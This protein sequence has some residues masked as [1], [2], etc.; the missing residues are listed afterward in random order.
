MNPN[1]LKINPPEI[2]S[3]YYRLCLFT[4]IRNLSMEYN[5]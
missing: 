3:G 4:K 2:I 1:H 5:P